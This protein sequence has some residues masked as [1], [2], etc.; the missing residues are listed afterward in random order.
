[1]PPKGILTPLQ[2]QFLQLFFGEPGSDPFY[3]T[4]GTALAGYYMGHRYSDDIDL[5]THDQSALDPIPQIGVAHFMSLTGDL[6]P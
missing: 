4:G 5:F 6:C 3:L 2:Q 1:M